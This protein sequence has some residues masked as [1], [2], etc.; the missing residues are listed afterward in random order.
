MG[1]MDTVT[2]SLFCHDNPVSLPAEIFHGMFVVGRFSKYVK[3]FII[4]G[5][6]LLGTIPVPVCCSHF[7]DRQGIALKA[8]YA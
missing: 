4:Q 7:C 6:R 8:F 3:D 5:R 1:L 2:E